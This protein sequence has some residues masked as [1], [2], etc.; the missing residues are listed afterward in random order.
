MRRKE[1]CENTAKG[2]RRQIEQLRAQLARY[3]EALEEDLSRGRQ[4][5]AERTREGLRF[6]QA[7]HDVSA[8]LLDDLRDQPEC[9]ELLPKLLDQEGSSDSD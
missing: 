3:A 2:L 1:I 4:Q 6:E 7:F 5:V 8:T 9:R